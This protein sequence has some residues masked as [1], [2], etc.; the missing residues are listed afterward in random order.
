MSLLETRVLIGSSEI[1][2]DQ[3]GAVELTAMQMCAAHLLR[4]KMMLPQ[5]VGNW[6]TKQGLDNIITVR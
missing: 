3:F 4:R 6:L 5:L 1:R 2:H